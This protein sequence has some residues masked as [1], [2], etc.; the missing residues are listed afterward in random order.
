M[1]RFASRCGLVLLLALWVAALTGCG[2]PEDPPN[3]PVKIVNVSG[4]NVKMSGTWSGCGDDG[5]GGSEFIR[6]IFDPFDTDVD[7]TRRTYDAP[8]CGGTMTDSEQRTGTATVEGIKTV[9]WAA[10]GPPLNLAAFDPIGVTKLLLSAQ[11]VGFRAIAVV[12]PTITPQRLYATLDDQVDPN[13][14]AQGYPN[15][16]VATYWLTRQ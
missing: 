11:F 2:L 7:V 4:S 13:L 9:P 5:S 1:D 15:E 16:L 10:P 8:S 14:D 3:G 6:L 12:D